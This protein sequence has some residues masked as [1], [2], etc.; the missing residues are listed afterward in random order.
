[1]RV[2]VTGAHG[3]V[4]RAL[5]KIGAEKKICTLAKDRTTLDITDSGAIEREIQRVGA[6]LV[7]N[8]AAMTDVDGAE[9]TPKQAFGVNRD[10]PGYLASAC[11]VKGIPLIHLS[12]DYV[13]D[14]RSKTPYLET[15]RTSP[16]NIYG[17]SKAAGE[18]MVRERLR[19][20]VILRT[21]WVYA[22]RGLNFVN[23]MLRCGQ[24][25]ETVRVVDDQFGCP[26]YA[27]DI[28]GAIWTIAERIESGQEIDWGTYH[29]CGAGV[30]SRHGFAEAIFSLAARHIPLK[31]KRVEP[32]STAHYPTPAQR[33]ARAVLDCSALE[34]TFRIER[35]PWTES[36]EEMVRSTFSV[37]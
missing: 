1:M 24:E 25:R 3:Q 14:G 8:A 11:A 26:T 29:Y 33:P 10:G 2:L 21:S 31:V 22:V 17:K 4:G 23:T 27:V 30:T 13:F 20:H 6:S 37:K 35:R 32:I 19:E 12:T 9:S 5:T 28:A 18:V 36:L 16:L 7:V 15:A 34:R